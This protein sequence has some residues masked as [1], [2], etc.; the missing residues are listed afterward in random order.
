MRML[1][2]RKVEMKKMIGVRVKMRE[3]EG[4][5]VKLVGRGGCK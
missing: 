1:W 2:K 5:I 4:E 3:T